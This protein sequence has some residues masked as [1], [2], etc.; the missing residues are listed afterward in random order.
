MRRFLTVAVLMCAS[1]VVTFASVPATFESRWAQAAGEDFRFNPAIRAQA[2]AATPAPTTTVTNG[3]PVVV[4]AP[5]PGGLSDI[6]GALQAGL[7][8]LVAGL[9]GFKKS[10]P[11]STAGAVAATPTDVGTIVSAVVGRMGGGTTALISDPSVRA[12]VDSALLQLERSGVPTTAINAAGSL[13]PGA[14]PF[15]S[16]LEPL[17]RK[18]VDSAL[19]ARAGAAPDPAAASVS[20]PA[21]L[22]G[23]LIKVFAPKLPGAA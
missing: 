10:A 12:A 3:T 15:V 8:A 5:P 14:A 16:I 18:A 20:L 6:L 13:V 19:A 2:P 1:V 23:D 21:S 4:Q 7:L 17:V 9:L 11:A 22:I